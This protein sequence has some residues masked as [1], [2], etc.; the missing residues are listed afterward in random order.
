MKDQL[1]EIVSAEF[2]VS[3]VKFFQLFYSDESDFQKKYHEV[4][5]DKEIHFEKWSSHPQ[6]GTFRTI[7]YRAPVHAAIGPST[8]RLEETQR[9]HLQ[10]ER[11]VI[12]LVSVMHDIPYGDYFRVE[13]KHE[14][15]AVSEESCKL[16]VYVGV[17]FT[18]KTFF[19]GKIKSNAAKESKESYSAW[20]S[21][22]NEELKKRKKKRLLISK[23]DKQDNEK[24]PSSP[25]SEN[26]VIENNMRAIPKL[27]RN[28]KTLVENTP[29]PFVLFFVI[30]LLVVG[31]LCVEV[32]LLTARVSL[33]E[34]KWATRFPLDLPCEE[35]IPG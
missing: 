6:Y 34:E 1:Q 33:L 11:L 20:I 14:V 3:V 16:T 9:Y 15:T 29:I 26:L 4:R 18:K 25:R 21:L 23:S 30:L 13:S 5:G 27:M 31:V 17:N 7:T 35:D 12:E 24:Q 10:K 32:T 28:F 2:P 22:A 19:E 8:T